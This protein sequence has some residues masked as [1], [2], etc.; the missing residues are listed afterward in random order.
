MQTI[1]LLPGRAARAGFFAARPR[2]TSRPAGCVALAIA[3]E[4]EPFE[5]DGEPVPL[6]PDIGERD[7][8]RYVSQPVAVRDR[9]GPRRDRAH[10][11]G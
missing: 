11:P 8:W 10:A 5:A 7:G 6:P 2:R 1:Q 9:G 3:D 4:L